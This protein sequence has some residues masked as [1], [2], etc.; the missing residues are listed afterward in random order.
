MLSIIMLLVACSRKM[1]Y[2]EMV[3]YIN[4]PKYGCIQEKIVNGIKFKAV[5]YPSEIMVY[6]EVRGKDSVTTEDVFSLRERYNKQ[7]YIILS[8]SNEGRDILSTA[9][10]KQQFELLIQQLSFKMEQNVLLTNSE[11]DTLVFIDS[12]FPRY[13]GVKDQSDLLLIF[14]R[15]KSEIEHLNLL[16]REFGLRTG[17]IK[18]KLSTIVNAVI[19]ENEYK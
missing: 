5:Y 3:E 8:F 11:N 6:H 14:E 9:T 4:N 13:F 15:K 17:D 16:I 2:E 18:F 7:H 1:T 10:D 12:R 19:K